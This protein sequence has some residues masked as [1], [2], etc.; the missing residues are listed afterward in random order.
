MVAQRVA[1]APEGEVRPRDVVRG[2]PRRLQRLVGR[3]QRPAHHRRLV[4]DDD[5]RRPRIRVDV[6]E[7][8]E[9]DVQAGFLA[10]LADRGDGRQFP[11]VHVAAGKDP[12]AVARLDRPADQREPAA[13]VRD[14]GSRRHLRV[15]VDDVSA[16]GADRPLRFAL[17]DPPRRERAAAGRAEPRDGGV[18]V[19]VVHVSGAGREDVRA[20][21]GATERGAQRDRP[22]KYNP[23]RCPS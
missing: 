11:A 3:G 14:H 9:P 13:P 4:D 5:R 17:L 23:A 2:E 15:Q 1:G 7:P 20:P 12:L 10:R 6:D 16:T 19:R 8:V 22:R 18:I 21:A